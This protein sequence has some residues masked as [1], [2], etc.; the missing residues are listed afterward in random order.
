MTALSFPSHGRVESVVKSVVAGVWI[1]G[2]WE[3]YGG[4]RMNNREDEAGNKR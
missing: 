4:R 3:V 1:G 2:V